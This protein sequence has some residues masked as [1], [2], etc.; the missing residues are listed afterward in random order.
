MSSG[1]LYWITGL[2]GAGKT[3]IGNKLYYRMKERCDTTVILDGDILKKIVG[4]DLGYTKEERLERAYR[5]CSLCEMLTSQGINVIICTIAMFDEVRQWNR[6]NIEKYVEIF[7]DVDMWILQ[8]RNRKG[9]YSDKKVNNVAGVDVEIEFPKTPDIVINN[10]DNMPIEESVQKILDY[11]VKKSNVVT[12]DKK[13]WDDYYKQIN[14]NVE[15]QTPSLFAQYV[16]GKYLRKNSSLIEL[17]CGNGRD[18]L[19]FAKNEINVTGIDSSET[20]IS[21]LVHKGKEYGCTFIC[22]DFV[23]ANAI[24]QIQ[25]DYC[26]SRFTL[27]AIT[28][29]QEKKLLQKTYDMLSEEGYLLIEARTINDGKYGFGQKVADNAFLLD[30]HYRRFINPEE[31][32]EALK[33]V[34]FIIVEAEE[35]DKFAPQK[36]EKC[37]CIRIVARKI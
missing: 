35:S 5:Y 23:N 7:L 32:L 33:K 15:L 24:F 8:K 16:L 12:H 26:Y 4:S 19:Y 9:L 1:I 11:P 10:N 18:S 6:E 20:A 29:Q 34:G 28:K 31:L 21:S 2:S 3:T 13:Y 17:G 37:V 36:G 30:G 27:H 14:E 25:Y 22:D